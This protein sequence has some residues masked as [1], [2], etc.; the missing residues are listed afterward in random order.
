[1]S[2]KFKV[3]PEHMIFNL[4]KAPVLEET[5]K[6]V[7]TYQSKLSE[8]QSTFAAESK[9]LQER[10]ARSYQTLVKDTTEQLTF[11]KDKK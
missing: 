1:M 5:L 11:A 3:G 9:V 7:A 10:Y 6:V 4:I 8:L 2:E